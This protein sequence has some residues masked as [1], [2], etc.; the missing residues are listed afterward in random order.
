MGYAAN[1]C[2]FFLQKYEGISCTYKLVILE[3]NSGQWEASQF[4]VW[5]SGN[6]DMKNVFYDVFMNLDKI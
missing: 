1:S 3:K 5:R 6:C 2:S 4:P